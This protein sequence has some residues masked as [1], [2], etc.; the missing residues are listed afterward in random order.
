MKIF[1]QLW[2]P[3]T[4]G[5]T[6]PSLVEIGQVFFLQDFSSSLYNLYNIHTNKHTH[7]DELLYATASQMLWWHQN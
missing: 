4:K 1:E 5:S 2:K 3:F 6:L 7:T